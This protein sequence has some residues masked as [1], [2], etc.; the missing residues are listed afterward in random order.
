M[1]KQAC[2]QDVYISRRMV[3]DSKV[4]FHICE[5]LS[6]LWFSLPELDSPLGHLALACDR[7]HCRQCT[8]SLI[9]PTLHRIQQSDLIVAQKASTSTAA[10]T[11]GCFGSFLPED[12]FPNRCNDLALLASLNSPMCLALGVKNRWGGLEHMDP[13]YCPVS[14]TAES[15]NL[16]QWITWQA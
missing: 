13:M 1:V 10:L 12:F 4:V 15:P 8:L 11:S 5:N 14:K 7:H 3:F 16:Y 9:L 2:C 6:Q